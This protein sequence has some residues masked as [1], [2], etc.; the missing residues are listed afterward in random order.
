MAIGLVGTAVNPSGPT[1]TYTSAGGTTLIVTGL[2]GTGGDPGTAAPSVSDTAGNRWQ[3]TPVDNNGAPPAAKLV[4]GGGHWVA[5]TAWCINAAAV[6][7]V[8]VSLTGQTGWYV[9]L[10][11]WQGIGSAGVGAAGGGLAVHNPS[12]PQVVT[13]HPGDLVIGS[14]FTTGSFSGPPVPG[15]EIN[16]GQVFGVYFLPGVIGPLTF[17]WPS[18]AGVDFASTVMVFSPPQPQP[19]AALLTGVEAAL[20]VRYTYM[21]TDLITGAVLADTLPL[22][23]QTF[24]SQLNGSGTLTGSLPFT[25]TAADGWAVN[26]GFVKALE[27][28]RAV[29]WVLQE[30]YPVWNGV[31]WDWP[32]TGLQ[33]GNLPISAQTMDSVWSHRLISDTIEYTAVDMFTVFLDLLTYGMTKDSTHISPLDPTPFPP[34]L[35]QQAAAVAGIH[36]NGSA[37][38][39][40]P[41]TAQYLYSDLRKVTDAWSDLTS[42]V[43]LEYWFQP[44]LDAN[45]NLATFVRLGKLGRRAADSGI[46]LTYPGNVLDYGYQR[47]GSQSANYIWAT[48]P[49]AGSAA[50]WLSQYPNGADITDLSNGYPLMEDTVS[51]NGSVVTAQSMIDGFAN[52]QVALKSQAMTEPVITVGGGQFPNAKDIVLGDSC[53]LLATSP[54][55]P[56]GAN[57]QPGLQVQVRIAGWTVTPPNA[58]QPESIQI[59]T[60]GVLRPANT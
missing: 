58:Q 18:A 9:S 35:V 25:G 46:Q 37:R 43:D 47:T 24:S 32:H 28:R 50:S 57:G 30:G 13:Y 2:V 48:A 4:S 15:T 22:N 33:A 60:S 14:A 17:T 42:S 11:E 26:K 23:V 21:S 5:F 10:S 55:H 36:F 16:T 54:L 20:E 51:W 52:G 7:S 3:Y 12:S 45:G 1:V 49:P 40:V 34:F 19:S 38:S 29:L 56:A 39:G 59:T 8:T 31:V 41:W 44:G 6:T 27:C 53:Q